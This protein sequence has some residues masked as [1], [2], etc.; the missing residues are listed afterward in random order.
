MHH[1]RT[2]I[3]LLL[4]L[5]LPMLGAQ[6][7]TELTPFIPTWENV[8]PLGRTHELDSALWLVHSASG[9]EFTF[10]GSRAEVTILGDSSASGAVGSQA[11]IAIE[12]D[13]VR[14]VDD[15]I[16]APEKTYT[17]CNFD[18]AK[19]VVVRI[20]KLSE[21][22]QSTCGVGE[23]RVDADAI[24]PTEKLPR[25]IEFI[26]DS[27]T[28]GYG[29]DDENRD[30]HFSTATEDATKTYAYLTAQA[31]GA[32]YSMVSFSGHGIISGYTTT[33]GQ[34]SSQLVPAY[35]GKLGY[36]WN[37]FLGQSPNQIDWNFT[38]FQPDA[39]V[40]NLGTNDDSYVKGDLARSAEFRQGY[41]AFMK[42]IRE[43]NP[44]AK[45]VCTLGIMGDAL[46]GSVQQAMLDYK[47]ETGDKNVAV[48]RFA[49]QQYSDGYAA[50][51][52]P[53]HKT[54]TKAAEKLTADLRKLM[55]W[56]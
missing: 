44:D 42:A 52:H 4:C 3:A 48:V 18:A 34:K 40:I 13:G 29:V 7:E 2:I 38:A 36:G 33:P 9:A 56:E 39:V 51:W 14:I 32:D 15:M 8:K 1:I 37:T 6:A 28:C 24:R 47:K 30:H 46:Y 23:I 41:V 16:D 31:L 22:M 53:T 43:K 49:V 20:V 27:I 55:G 50:D 12:V 21:S 45:I 19:D 26:G 25:R 17:V 35:Y 11:R 5:L 54:H 10:H